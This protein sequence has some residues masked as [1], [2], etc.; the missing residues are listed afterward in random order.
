MKKRLISLV[1]GVLVWAA[2][3]NFVFL[4]SFPMNAA[5]AANAA[6]GAGKEKKPV[7]MNSFNEV[8]AQLD[9]GGNFYLYCGTEKLAKAVD[10]FALKLRIMMEQK[11]ENPEEKADALNIFDFVYGMIKNSGLMD[12]SGLGISTIALEPD[13][14]RT[15]MVC[16]HYKGKGTGL[17]WNLVKPEPHALTQVGLLP[18]DTVLAGFSDFGLNVL[19]EWIKK[20]ALTSNLPK[21]KQGILFL[22]PMLQQQGIELGKLLNSIDEAG[23]VLTLDSRKKAAIPMG[24][25]KPALEIPEP[26]LAFVLAV[27][28]DSLFNLLQS[29]MPFAQKSPNPEMKMLQIPVPPMPFTVQPVIIQ[30]D[31]LLIIAS[32]NDIVNAMFAAKKSGKGLIST[33]EFKKLSE[34]IPTKGNSFRFGSARLSQ[35]VMEIQSNLVR[36]AAEGKDEDQI[37]MNFMKMFQEKY[38]MFGVLRNTDEGTLYTMNHGF[39]MEAFLLLPLSVTLGIVAAIAIPNLLTAKEKGKQ[40]A[41]MGDMKT[42]GM[43]INMYIA[44]NGKA[45]EG[46]TI[47]EIKD[48][49]E[50]FYI[51]TLPLKDGWDNDFHYRHG[52]GDKQKEFAVASGGRDGVFDG[53]EQSGVYIV[54]SMDG[55]ERDI[56][57][58]D[59]KFTFGPKV[60]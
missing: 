5:S 49:L 56:I 32:N 29:K 43:A 51:K 58:A 20:E 1:T 40:K 4:G 23:Y 2:L 28:D 33:A 57:F 9:K 19:W 30:K 27:K 47:L 39:D 31:G 24:K 45:P 35:V 53:W 12:V 37:L 22:E 44:D 46:K 34:G 26:A 52:T 25:D 6:N 59:G 48:K 10:E 38:G 15:K 41:T 55:F 42:I 17:I 3:V 36:T 21:L 16:H 60:K 13:L 11:I 7:E 54:T 14:N 50:P 18:A 8:T